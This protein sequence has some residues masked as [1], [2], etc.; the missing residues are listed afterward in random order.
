MQP[1]LG[2]VAVLCFTA[3]LTAGCAF[4][5]RKPDG[6]RVD[7]GASGAGQGALVAQAIGRM[8]ENVGVRAVQG[9]PPARAPAF[10]C[11]RYYK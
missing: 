4:G 3:T 1:R 9:E 7:T 6:P 8:P 10:P 2:I 5:I 11:G